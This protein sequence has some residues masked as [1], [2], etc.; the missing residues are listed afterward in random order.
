MACGTDFTCSVNECLPKASQ[1]SA[2]AEC[3]SLSCVA[4]LCQ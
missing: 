4:G 1:C 2:P 3:C